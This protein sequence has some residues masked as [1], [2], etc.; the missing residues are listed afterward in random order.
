MNEASKIS[1]RSQ[2]V[3]IRGAVLLVTLVFMLL[4]ALIAGTVMQTAVFQ[5]RM[6]G[7]DQYLEE[8]YHRA[9]AIITELSLN[10]ENFTLEGVVGAANCPVGVQ[11]ADC[12]RSQLELAHSAEQS[13][14]ATVN[15]RV[16]RQDPL[17]WRG[18]PIRESQ[19]VVS[20]SRSFDAALFEVEVRIDGDQQ[21]PGTAHLAQGIAVRVPAHR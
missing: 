8:A 9:H 16:V 6:A 13:G 21:V 7:N 17:F 5:L 3:P 12:D 10:A 11:R 18:F 1:A 2:S 15:Y 20:S 4:L 14:A 19:A